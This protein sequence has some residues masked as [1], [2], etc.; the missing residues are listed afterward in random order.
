MA[1]AGEHRIRSSFPGAI[2]KSLEA[3]FLALEFVGLY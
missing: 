2:P 1:N 3:D